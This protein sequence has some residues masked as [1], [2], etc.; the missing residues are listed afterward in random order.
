MNYEYSRGAYLISTDPG[1]L[2]VLAIHHY[3]SE[4]SYWAPGIP[5]ELVE[6]ALRHSFNFGL[7]QHTR[8]IGLARVIT[9]YTTFAYLCDV[10]VLADYR[11]QGLSKWLVG[12]VLDCPALAGLRRFMLM[13][14]DAH[15]LYAR[16]G[17]QA[18]QDAS[19]AMEISRPGLYQ[20]AKP[21]P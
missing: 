10:Y 2:D 11:G 7:Y 4:E 5:L 18:L 13:T 16:F 6:K 8:Q 12:C 3:L 21:R 14:R 15:G 17:F 1:K 9:D 19:K 20:K